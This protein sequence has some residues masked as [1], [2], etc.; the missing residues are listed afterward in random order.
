[1]ALPFVTSATSCAD[2]GKTVLPYINQLYDLPQK[3]AQTT[4]SVQ[5]LKGLYLATNPLVT[6]LAFSLFLV[7]IFLVISEINKNYS[8]VDRCW[9]LLPT[10]YNAHYVAYA[11]A[12]GLPTQR[13]DSLIIISAVWSVSVSP[14]INYYRSSYPRR[15]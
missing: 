5:N 6:A 10:I 14:G 12:I 2:F 15:D 13:L 1:M 11:H 9:S 8:Q 3:I 7:P 4:P